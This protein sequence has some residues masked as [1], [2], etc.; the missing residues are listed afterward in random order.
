MLY[1]CS[2]RTKKLFAPKEN[3]SEEEIVQQVAEFEAQ[4]WRQKCMDEDYIWVRVI[5]QI[6]ILSKIRAPCKIRAT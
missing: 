3:Y 6:R 4:E 1:E 2:Q 5:E